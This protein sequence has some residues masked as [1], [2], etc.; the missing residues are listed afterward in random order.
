MRLYNINPNHISHRA[1]VWQTTSALLHNNSFG[2]WFRTTFGVRQGC[3]LSPIFFN[4]FLER[5]IANVLEDHVRTASIGGRTT[6]AEDLGPWL[7]WWR[8]IRKTSDLAKPWRNISGLW[9]QD[10]CRKTKLMR[11]ATNLNILGQ[12]SPR[13]VQTRNTQD[14]SDHY[15][16]HQTQRHL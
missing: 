14:F 5:I 13:R 15:C 1:H 12:L 3:L 9:P 2:E 11:R 8:R 10:Q 4:I 7:P 16:N 6:Y